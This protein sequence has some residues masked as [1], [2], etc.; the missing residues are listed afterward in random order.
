MLN[1]NF[2][3]TAFAVFISNKTEPIPFFK[4]GLFKGIFEAKLN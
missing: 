4:F 3:F 2:M 1:I